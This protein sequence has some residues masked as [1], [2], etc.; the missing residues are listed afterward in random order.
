MPRKPDFWVKAMNKD[1]NEKSKVG[2]A[3]L[4]PDKS[5]SIDL[6]PFV[7]LTAGKE[8]VITLFPIDRTAINY[9]D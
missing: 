9:E 7:V 6:N 2:A 4:N 3:W 8:L 1:T 5:V